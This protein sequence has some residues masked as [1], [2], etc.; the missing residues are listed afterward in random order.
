MDRDKMR[1]EIFLEKI[2]WALGISFQLVIAKKQFASF[3]IIPPGYKLSVCEVALA[4]TSQ[5]DPTTF[6]YF[7]QSS[8]RQIELNESKFS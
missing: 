5:N 2:T 1:K 7:L 4:E 6:K 8:N 3:V